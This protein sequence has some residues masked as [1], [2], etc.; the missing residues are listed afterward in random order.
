MSLAFIA[1]VAIFFITVFGYAA[2]DR[3]E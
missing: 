1:F 3:S 2:R